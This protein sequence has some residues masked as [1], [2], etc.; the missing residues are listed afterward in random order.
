MPTI[1]VE[2]SA[3]RSQ[4]QKQRLAQ[5]ITTAMVEHSGCTIESVQMVFTDV[6]PHNWVI[7]GKFL[8]PAYNSPLSD[9]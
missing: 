2:M 1:H 5:A 6:A 9:S 3:G 7:G 8:G 4:E